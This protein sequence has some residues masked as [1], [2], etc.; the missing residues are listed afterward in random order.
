[1]VVNKN[2]W[3]LCI[4]MQTK[5]VVNEGPYYDDQNLPIERMQMYTRNYQL[6]GG[7]RSFQST[8]P[9]QNEE[10]SFILF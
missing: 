4:I 6:A 3:Q 10:C 2:K 8:I 1:M 9:Y 5:I 7:T